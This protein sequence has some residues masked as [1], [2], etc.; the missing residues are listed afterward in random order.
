MTTFSIVNAQDISYT[1]DF[2]SICFNLHVSQTQFNTVFPNTSVSQAP[3]CQFIVIYYC[4][5]PVR[6]V[7]I[8]QD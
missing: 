6:I 8:K 7:R 5:T 3:S 4:R 2:V 1:G